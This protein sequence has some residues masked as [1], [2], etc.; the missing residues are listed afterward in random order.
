LQL[1]DDIGFPWTSR[2]SWRPINT[3]TLQLGC[4]SVQT[5]FESY[6]SRRRMSCIGLSSGFCSKGA[7]VAWQVP[8]CSTRLDHRMASKLQ[9]RINL[10][11]KRFYR[12]GFWEFLQQLCWWILNCRIACHI[13]MPRDMQVIKIEIQINRGTKFLNF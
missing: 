1:T 12:L 3:S 2:K 7:W 9:C 10:L 6:C 11:C 13:S 8:L 4:L 5:T